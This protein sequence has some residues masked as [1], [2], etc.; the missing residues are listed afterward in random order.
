MLETG[1][2]NVPPLMHGYPN[3]LSFNIQHDMD[4]D[5]SGP[6]HNLKI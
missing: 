4:M 6:I 2:D 1:C 5:I 3:I